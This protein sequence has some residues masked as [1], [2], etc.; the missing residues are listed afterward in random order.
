MARPASITIRTEQIGI[1]GAVDLNQRIATGKGPN[2]AFRCEDGLRTT[3][4]WSES[5]GPPAPDRFKVRFSED[6]THRLSRLT[7]GPFPHN[8][9]LDCGFSSFLH[10]SPTSRSIVCCGTRPAV[11]G[12][13]GGR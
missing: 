9:Y 12:I 8:R 7:R 13:G 1:L 2:L 5:T 3:L 4:V 11:K 6:C 10:D